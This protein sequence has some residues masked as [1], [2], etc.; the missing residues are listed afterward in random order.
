MSINIVSV[1]VICLHIFYVHFQWY[2]VH[3]N[4]TRVR[5]KYETLWF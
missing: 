3:E 5:N 2:K 4:Y 1:L